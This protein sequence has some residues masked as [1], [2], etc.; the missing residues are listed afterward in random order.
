M[1]TVILRELDRDGIMAPTPSL[2]TGSAHA[3]P[4]DASRGPH[5]A[6]AFGCF[7]FDVSV[8]TIPYDVFLNWILDIDP[9]RG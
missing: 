5:A 1:C 4:Q 6:E 8:L 3:M 9:H 2:V 7:P